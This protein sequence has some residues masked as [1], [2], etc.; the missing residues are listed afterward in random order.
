MSLSHR[1]SSVPYLLGGLCA[2]GGVVGYR[3]GSV[4][5]LAGGLGIG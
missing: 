3:K 2:A 5:S 1:E 4:A